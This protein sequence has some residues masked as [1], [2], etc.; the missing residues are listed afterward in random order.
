MNLLDTMDDFCRIIER[1]IWNPYY[2]IHF[3]LVHIGHNVRFCMQV[4]VKVE[5][6]R[7][8]DHMNNDASNDEKS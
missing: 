6:K 5:H 4:I 3:F 1:Y 8:H 7:H 2:W